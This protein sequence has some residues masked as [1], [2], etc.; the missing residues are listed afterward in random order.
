MRLDTVVIRMS[1]NHLL[2]KWVHLFSLSQLKI[3]TNLMRIVCLF[4]VRINE[5]TRWIESS[6]CTN[7]H[8]YVQLILFNQWPILDLLTDER[9]FRMYS[10]YRW[11][12]DSILYSRGVGVLLVSK[13]GSST[14]AFQSISYSRNWLEEDVVDETQNPNGCSPK[15]TFFNSLQYS[16]YSMVSWK[17]EVKKEKRLEL[18]S[19]LLPTTGYGMVW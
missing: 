14:I 6:R 10:F 12:C 13:K 3:R 17:F 1:V 15:M 16:N 5:S 2:V 8:Q 18:T 7:V 11:W 4:I 9:L 19:L